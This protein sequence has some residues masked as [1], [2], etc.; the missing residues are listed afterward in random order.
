MLVDPVPII[1]PGVVTDTL[2]GP[3]NP[4]G[5]VATNDVKLLIVTLSAGILPNLTIEPG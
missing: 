1:P 2:T 5:V 3:I 4:G